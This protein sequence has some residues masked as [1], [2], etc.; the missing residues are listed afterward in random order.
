MN[1][2][3]FEATFEAFPQLLLQFIIVY[4][5]FLKN[6][7]GSLTSIQ[8]CQILSSYVSLIWVGSK[9][10]IFAL[11]KRFHLKEL[12]F[13]SEILCTFK[14]IIKYSYIVGV[15]TLSMGVISSQDEDFQL[16]LLPLVLITMVGLLGL[17]LQESVFAIFKPKKKSDSRNG[18]EE[19]A[20]EEGAQEEGAQE[21]GAQEEGAQEEGA[22]EEGAQEEGAQEE[23]T[24]EEGA[25]EEGA[26]EEGDQEEGD[27]PWILKRK[28][29]RF[30]LGFI[31]HTLAL[32]ALTLHLREFV[33][34]E[35]KR[36][37]IIHALVVDPFDFKCNK[38]EVCILFWYFILS[39]SIYKLY[40]VA[41][42][43]YVKT[44][45]PKLG[46][47]R[48]A[49]YWSAADR[50]KT[51][52]PYW[53]APLLFAEEGLFF[54]DRWLDKGSMELKCFSCAR[55]VCL[56][57]QEHHRN[58]GKLTKPTARKR[59]DFFK[60][61]HDFKHAESCTYS[62]EKEL[63]QVSNEKKSSDSEHRAPELRRILACP[64]NGD[65]LQQLELKRILARLGF[66]HEDDQM[67]QSPENRKRSVMQILSLNETPYMKDFDGEKLTGQWNA[68]CV[69]CHRTISS[70][71]EPLSSAHFC[72]CQ[73]CIKTQRKDII[74]QSMRTAHDQNCPW[75]KYSYYVSNEYPDL[76]CKLFG[77]K[78]LQW[79]RRISI[80]FG[81]VPILP[82]I[83]L[84]NLWAILMFAPVVVMA[85][86]ALANILISL[87]M[88]ITMIF[89]CFDLFSSK[90]G[91]LKSKWDKRRL[92]AICFFLILAF[93]LVVGFGSHYI[94][95]R[96]TELEVQPW[97]LH[98]IYVLFWLMLIFVVFM[99]NLAFVLRS[100]YSFPSDH[101][102]QA[103]KMMIGQKT[104]ITSDPV[105][106]FCNQLNYISLSSVCTI[107]VFL[108]SRVYWVIIAWVVPIIIFLLILIWYQCWNPLINW[109]VKR[110]ILKYQQDSGETDQM[111]PSSEQNQTPLG[112]EYC[113]NALFE[114]LTLKL[115]DEEKARITLKPYSMYLT[116]PPKYASTFLGNE[117][118]NQP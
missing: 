70:K 95:N 107:P 28:A 51:F 67:N 62:I 12:N 9:F 89:G 76:I 65:D 34:E 80:C 46:R 16:Y 55:S 31:V 118:Q 50:M 59:S 93:G 69:W 17:D 71:S 37:R 48:Y 85:E 87:G 99:D 23:G 68:K 35:T 74:Y 101:P 49:N 2:F 40:R 13:T 117:T 100:D 63:F 108:F 8:M 32:I 11:K 94:S 24:Q 36:S 82:F 53:P 91:G 6:G 78:C 102:V 30:L 106:T 41:F 52:P 105:A 47:Y 98:T 75:N 18:Q 96:E 115:K 104:F 77:A 25:Q 64:S 42:R 60:L 20:Q 4:L 38:T 73:K 79:E 88:M 84:C 29:P 114:I 86:A 57:K 81:I 90:F 3:Y 22:Q 7:L 27:D 10:E 58:G 113:W 15:V 92:P 21:E 116:I 26:H 43:Y 39:T 56:P 14:M 45:G 103:F 112:P 1:Y 19:C 109:L 111:Q 66:I 97:S 5:Q 54:S 44:N 83:I 110:V 72:P 33:Q 61:I